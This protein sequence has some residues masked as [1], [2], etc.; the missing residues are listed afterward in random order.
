MPTWQ[1]S[2][3]SELI[4]IAQEGE[5]EAFGELYQRYAFQFLKLR[6]HSLSHA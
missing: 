6:F 4:R 2:E 3:D 5:S 1:E